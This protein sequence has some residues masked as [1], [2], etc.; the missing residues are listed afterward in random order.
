MSP[1]L[2]LEPF[3]NY[4]SLESRAFLLHQDDG[5]L[6]VPKQYQSRIDTSRQSRCRFRRNRNYH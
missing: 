3:L 2:S 6:K 1:F 4:S 5:S